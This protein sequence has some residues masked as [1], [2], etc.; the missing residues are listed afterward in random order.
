LTLLYCTDYDPGDHTADVEDLQQA[1]ESWSV[2]ESSC[3]STASVFQRK[4][5]GTILLKLLQRQLFLWINNVVIVVSH[6]LFGQ[7]FDVLLW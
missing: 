6:L 3:L 7:Y 4:I 2:Q 5:K 1:T